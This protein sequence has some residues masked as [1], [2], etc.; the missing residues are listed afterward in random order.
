MEGGI[1]EGSPAVNCREGPAKYSLDESN[2]SKILDSCG[3]APCGLRPPA[4]INPF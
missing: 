3:R 4:D 1:L 2:G